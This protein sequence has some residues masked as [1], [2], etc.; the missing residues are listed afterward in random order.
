MKVGDLVYVFGVG[1]NGIIV[2]FD[3]DS[4]FSCEVM[5]EPSI[6]TG[7]IYFY[8]T[9]ES[10]LKVISEIDD[11]RDANDELHTDS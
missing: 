1:L 2:R 7:E 3:P 5:F 9:S 8:A 6:Y 4:L 10:D 11:C